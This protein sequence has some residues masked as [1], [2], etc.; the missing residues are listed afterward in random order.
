MK[1]WI[2]LLLALLLAIPGMGEEAIPEAEARVLEA[3]Q[4]ALEC[5]RDSC[6]LTEEETTLLTP[7]VVL[8]GEEDALASQ[9][10][11]YERAWW[12]ITFTLPGLADDGV[13]AITV[14]GESRYT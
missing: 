10:V 5:L 2:A 11:D 7:V 6:G 4:L 9:P 13:I 3:C 1:K 14:E 8:V 12:Q